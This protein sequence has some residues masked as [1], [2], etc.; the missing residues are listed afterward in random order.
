MPA[1]AC[2]SCPTP[3]I[4][5]APFHAFSL[6]LLALAASAPAAAQ[7]RTLLFGTA[8]AGVSK[9][10]TEWGLD[11]AWPSY[12]NM[13]RGVA[14]MGQDQV[15]FVRVSF[16]VNAQLV[17]GEL[18]SAQLATLTNRV[19]LANLAGAGKP[20]TM[21]PDTEAGVDAW[22]KNGSE[23]IPSRWVQAMEATVRALEAQGK[24]LVSAAPFNEPDYGWGQGTV[25]NLYDILGLL[26]TSPEFPGVALAGPSTLSC[27]AADTWYNP[28]KN[29]VT[30]GTTH[31]LAGSFDN[32]VSFYENVLNSGDHAVNE[33]LHNVCEAIVGAE[34]GLQTGI[35][36][37]TAE[38]TRGTFVKTNQGVRLG[39]AEHRP[40]WTAA[41]VYRAPSGAVQAFV[42]ASERQAVTTSYRFFNRDRKV[43]YDGH[44]PRHDYTVILPGGNGYSVNQPNAE[45]LVNI[46]WGADVQPAING[47]YILVNRASGKVMEVVGGS[48]ADGADIRQNTYTGATH[49]QWDVVPLDSRTGGDY[50][51]F[52]IKAAHSGKAAD[53][54]HWSHDDG[55]DIVQWTAGVNSNQ[56]YFLQ[57]IG[58]GWFTIRNRWSTK[59]LDVDNASSADGANIFQWTGPNGLNQQWRLIPAGAAVEF[60]AP[61]AP[62]GLAAVA[63][64]VSVRLSWNAVAASDLAGYTVLRSENTVTG[65]ETIARDLAA[66]SFVDESAIPGRTYYY[67]VLAADRSLNRSSPSPFASATPTGAPTLVARYAFEGDVRDASGNG[68]DAEPPAPARYGAGRVGAASLVLDGSGTRANLPPGVAGYENLTVAAWVFW[69]GG[70]SWQRVFDFGNGTDQYLFLTP[71]AGGAGLRFAIKNGGAEQQLNAPALPVGQWT[72]VAVALGGATARLYVNGA[73]VASSSAF[74]IK[75]SDFSP[76]LNYIGDS[77]FDADPGFDGLVDDFRVYNHALPAADVAALAS[78]GPADQSAATTH[79]KFDE[80]SGVTAADASGLGW[81]ATLVNG[82]TWQSGKIGNAVALDPA[83]SQ[84]L[85]LPSHVV[86]GLADFTISAWVRPASLAAWMRVFDFGNDT[87]PTALAG[88]YMTLTLDNGGAPSFRITTAGYVNEQ[89]INATAPLAVGAWSHVAVTLSGAVGR[90]YVNGALVGANNAMTL[91]P[92]SLGATTRNYLGRSQFAADP[93]F[94]GALDEFRIYPRALASDEL[95]ALAAGLP[96]APGGL[97][98]TPGPLQ[99]Q[100]AWNAVANASAYTLRY[101]T[102]VAGPYSTLS[103]GSTA[104]AYTHAGLNFGQTYYYTVDATTLAGTGPATSPTSATPQ[105]A[106]I[107]DAE[108]QSVKITLAIGADQSSNA[109]LAI[110]ASVPGHAYQAQYTNDLLGAWTDIGATQ[111]G[112]GAQLLLALPPMPPS[113]RAFYRVVIRR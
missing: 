38:L 9:A 8:D 59:C 91:R 10:I 78:P 2:P 36:W 43:F 21:T 52:T 32:Y 70:A 69:N 25:T 71:S 95:T 54:L 101:A 44:G 102:A 26:Q 56:H 37:G 57:Y 30:E 112:T 27:D 14:Y 53:L 67:R 72:H 106:I 18:A 90:L 96:P 63:N 111:A 1:P 17:N 100:L 89:Q 99:I 109:T 75:P 28:I 16:P 58:G 88:A 68:N 104:T 81:H 4:S 6:A 86:G 62:T 31:Q 50:S 83:S 97:A 13:L 7:D 77:Q 35:W 40:N 113:P 24:T 19:N 85:A 48:T 29:R 80:T 73:E 105:S 49:Q 55:G 11:T 34:Y 108:I 66:T 3:R 79:L 94:Y 41:A 47:R 93:Y 110:P 87:T 33:E 22:F 60:V 84:H 5:R 92:S 98:A 15:D 76:A 42:G 39:Y 82:A 23:V 65:Y 46:T 61:A 51:Y 20:V 103:T 107:T 74:T 12:D 64:P 45:K